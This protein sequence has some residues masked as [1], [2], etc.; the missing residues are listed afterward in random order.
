MNDR[1]SRWHIDDAGEKTKES[2]PEWFARAMA[3]KPRSHRIDVNGC[4]IH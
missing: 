4:D 1:S 3:E 2:V